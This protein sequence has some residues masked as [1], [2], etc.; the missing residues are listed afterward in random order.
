MA[1]YQTVQELVRE[2]E[3][4]YISGSETT[5]SKYV[6]FD[7]YENINKVDAYLNSKHIS[8]ETD[9]KNREKPFFNIVIAAVNIWYRA[10]DIDRRNITIRA[11]KLKNKITAFLATILIGEWMR[12]SNFG[13]F[14]NDW[15]R[16]LSR[17]GSAVSKFIEK[18]GE[19]FAETIPWNKLIVDAVDFENNPVIEKLWFTPAQLRKNKSYD[20]DFV[21]QLIDKSGTSRETVGRD[22]KDNLDN[23]IP[24]YEMHGELPLSYLTDDEDDEDTFVQQMQTVCFVES[25]DEDGKTKKDD[26]GKTVFEDFTL[27]RGKEVKNPYMITHLIK[28]D[29]RSMSIGAVENLFEAQWMLNHSQKAIKDQLD[30]AS[31]LIYQT[32][33]GNF[34]GQ[35]ALSSID[36]GDILIHKT[37]EPLTQINN[38]SH[39]ITS[40]QSFGRQW[41]ALGLQINGINE[42]MVTAPKSGTAWRQTEAALAEAHSLFEL[43]T[44]NKGLAIENM[45]REYVIPFIKKKMDTTDEISAILSE[46]QIKK[47][48]EMFVP[49]EAIR[50]VNRKILNKVLNDE[51]VTK[52]DQDLDTIEETTNLESELQTMGNQR[53]ISPSDI[54]TKTWKKVLKNLEW[55]VEVD[56]TG[57]QRDTQGVLATLGT[58][59]QTIAGNPA[60]LQDPNAKAIFNKIISLTGAIDP[61]EISAPVQQAQ[62]VP[63][64]AKVGGEQPVI[65]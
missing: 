31:K 56:V 8:G 62:P 33:D 35:N 43:M 46:Q 50:R 51:D 65:Q 4:N 44:E 39:D 59:L 37:N 45:M 18:D 15:G 58:T 25:K 12:K 30:L 52:E 14:L 47:I 11:T 28:E 13:V 19:L 42:A 7:L 1:K 5:I 6:L 48:D 10:T 63:A 9:S 60:I 16:T 27:Y 64:G 32:S 2:L 22:K 40:L 55:E 53:F 20:Q 29:G 21:E 23:Y 49:N 54:K 41:E 26:N 38:T 24:V 17:Y 61:L 57:E 36:N 3:Q 34:V